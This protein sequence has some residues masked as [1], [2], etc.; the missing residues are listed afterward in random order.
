ME[1]GVSRITV[2]MPTALRQELD[3]LAA[4]EKRSVNAQV[5]KLIEESLR[6]EAT[7]GPPALHIPGSTDEGCR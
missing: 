3:A 4:R 6:R 7:A 5:V 2:R 1:E